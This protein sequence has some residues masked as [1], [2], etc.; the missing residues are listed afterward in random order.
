MIPTSRDLGSGLGRG[1]MR[2]RRGSDNL[3][4]ER[5][6]TLILIGK[7]AAERLSTVLP[8]RTSHG[9]SYG[10]SRS[11]LSDRRGGTAPSSNSTR[12]STAITVAVIAG[13]GTVGFSGKLALPASRVVTATSR[14]RP[15][16]LELTAK[17]RHMKLGKALGMPSPLG[18][19]GTRVAQG[20]VS[21]PRVVTELA[22][23]AGGKK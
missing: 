7:P 18:M 2:R 19:T 12:D 10:R 13:G 11:S 4:T 5:R 15:P 14:F 3:D 16:Q 6:S 21:S 9:R 17:V 23:R 1:S 22:H 20:R 8:T